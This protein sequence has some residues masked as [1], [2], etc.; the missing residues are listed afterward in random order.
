[1]VVDWKLIDTVFIDMDGTLLDLNFD[2]EFWLRHLPVRYS[3]L[4][5]QPLG[6]VQD[7]IRSLL[8][9]HVGTLNWYSAK[10]W[11]N[12][13]GRLPQGSI[14]KDEPSHYIANTL[15]FHCVHVVNNTSF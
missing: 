7:K 13:L 3:E 11:S 8:L 12:E 1:M 10:F 2:N 14:N 4:F 15:M 9:K 5:N 6:E